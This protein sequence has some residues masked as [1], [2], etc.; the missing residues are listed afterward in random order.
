MERSSS[1][2]I[3]WMGWVNGMVFIG[4]WLSNSKITFGANICV[5]KKVNIMKIQRDQQTF[6]GLAKYAE[7][8]GGFDEEIKGRNVTV[9]SKTVSDCHQCHQLSM[10]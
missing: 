1:Y 10:L 5:H 9:S 3:G 4:F 2:R 6:P 7:V 8:F